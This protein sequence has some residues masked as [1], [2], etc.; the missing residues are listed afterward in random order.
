MMSSTRPSLSHELVASPASLW[1]GGSAVAA[2]ESTNGSTAI[3][4]RRRW[5]LS[6]AGAVAGRCPGPTA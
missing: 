2:D 3:E 4:G 5:K 6:S 1:P